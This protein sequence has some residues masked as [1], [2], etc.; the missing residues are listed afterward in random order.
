MLGFLLV[1]QSTV[2]LNIEITLL[3]NGSEEKKGK[4]DMEGN[5]N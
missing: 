1:E 5:F 2:S 3:N 4:E